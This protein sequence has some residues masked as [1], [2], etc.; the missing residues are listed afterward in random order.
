MTYF[1]N[2][3]SNCVKM[4]EIKYINRTISITNIEKDK[5]ICECECIE[6]ER[7]DI[8]KD[9]GIYI[10]HI[11]TQS[12]FRNKGY[13]SNMLYFMINFCKINNYKYIILDDST[14]S[15]PPHNLYC[16]LNCLV[17]KFDQ[18][19]NYIWVKWKDSIDLSVDEERLFKF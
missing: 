18:D 12:E 17:K 16:K 1:C 7:T 5:L 2:N 19:N 10:T 3:I 14:D 13:A 9:K 6:I 4:Y 15:S 8:S 11:F